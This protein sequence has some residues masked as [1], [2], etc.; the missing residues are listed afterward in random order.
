MYSILAVAVSIAIA[1]LSAFIYRRCGRDYAHAP[2]FFLVYGLSNGLGVLIDSVLLTA[3]CFG[4]PITA[5][6]AM[7]VVSLA[8]ATVWNETNRHIGLDMARPTTDEIKAEL[9]IDDGEDGGEKTE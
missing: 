8:V 4:Y 6:F 3:M 2:L 1:S 5:T 7:F 9:G